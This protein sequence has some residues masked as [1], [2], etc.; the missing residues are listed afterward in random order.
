MKRTIYLVLIA[1][2]AQFTASGQGLSLSTVVIDPGHGGKDPGAVSK[3]GKT[4]EKTLT[5][6]IAKKLESKIR[7]ECPGVNVVLTRSTDKNVDLGDRAA[8]ANKENADLFISIHINSTAKS[9]P[10]GYSVH[11]LGKSSDKNRD[12]FAYNMDVCKRENSVILLE[13][14]YTTTYQ[15]FDPSDPESFIFMQLMQN[16]HLEQSLEFAQDISDKLK[17]GP[18]AANRGIWQN[19]FLVLWKTSMPSVLVELGFISNA[20]DLAALKSESNRD[21]I[22]A[23]LCEAFKV[24]KD[25]YDMSLSLDDKAP[26]GAAAKPA[27]EEKKVEEKKADGKKA[28]QD[29]PATASVR[30]GIQIFAGASKLSPKDKAFMGYEPVIVNVGKIY[31]YVIAV[32]DSAAKTKEHLS[33]VRKKYPDAFMVKIEGDK[34]S[35]YK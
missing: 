35:L 2:L 25:R 34:L 7:S 21:K 15:G 3:D 22:A 17:G 19:P 11:V 5:L 4:Y 1:L 30:Y 13:D 23:R 16:S 33:Q 12:L 27:V 28:A 6:D 20:N 24:Y 14:D 18:I 31:K 8:I 26:A 29:K 10:N 32:E 9:G